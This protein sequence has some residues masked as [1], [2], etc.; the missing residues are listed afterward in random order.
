MQIEL[1]SPA[2]LQQ[3]RSHIMAADN[4]VVCCHVSPDGDAVGSSLAWA[5]VLRKFDKRPVIIVPD[6][7][8]DFLRWLP[9]VETIMRY[10]KHP[11]EADAIIADADVVFCLDFNELS[12]TDAMQSTLQ[13][14]RAKKIL[15]DH[16]L[17]PSINAVLSI[18]RPPLSSTCEIVFR[19]A[20]QLGLFESLD[21]KFAVPDYCGM[22][23]DT[24]GFTFNSNAPEIFFIIGQL[25]TKGI[26]KDKIYRNVYNVFS[27]SRLRLQ[28][29]VLYEKMNVVN[30]CKAAF[31]ALTRADLMRFHYVKGDGEGLVNMPLQIKGMRLS[32]SLREDTER[33]NYILVSLRSVDDFPCNEM[34]ARFFNGGGHKN[35]SGGKLFC[36]IDEAIEITRRA[37]NHYKKELKGN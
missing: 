20:W 16:H 13:A 26:D 5:E 29:Y 21:R 15:I 25:L 10:D 7:F 31:F 17:N 18:S 34:A 30:D 8:P 11:D 33:D 12:R 4:I 36:S 32:I 24:G 37:I 22:M 14:T 19:L 27:E 28:G 23:T 9:G 6:Q 1:L 3:L 2:E 35:A